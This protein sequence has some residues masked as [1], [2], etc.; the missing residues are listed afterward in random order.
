MNEVPPSL[1]RVARLFRVAVAEHYAIYNADELP[2][3]QQP[4]CL[5][6]LLTDTGLDFTVEFSFYTEKGEVVGFTLYVSVP[7]Q[8]PQ[9]KDLHDFGRAVLAHPWPL[10]PHGVDAQLWLSLLDPQPVE[11]NQDFELVFFGEYAGGATPH[12]LKQA[13]EDVGRTLQAVSEFLAPPVPATP[14][15]GNVLPLRARSGGGSKRKRR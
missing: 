11:Q 12:N 15:G 4:Y 9:P 1:Q 5:F 13:V 7:V 2:D 6:D 10:A 14:V 3:A 8:A